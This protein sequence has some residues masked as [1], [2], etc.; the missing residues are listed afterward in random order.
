ML[1]ETPS[2]AGGAR[3]PGRCSAC[4]LDA[5]QKPEEVRILQ[6]IGPDRRRHPLDGSERGVILPVVV[7]RGDVTAPGVC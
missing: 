5:G 1:D 2:P 6:Q 4:C 3:S 7:Q